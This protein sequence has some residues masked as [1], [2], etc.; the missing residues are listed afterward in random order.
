MTL[1]QFPRVTRYFDKDGK[2]TPEGWKLF[3]RMRGQVSRIT[4]SATAPSNPSVGDIWI[5]IS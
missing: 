5:D 3:E 4:V 1:E 2:M